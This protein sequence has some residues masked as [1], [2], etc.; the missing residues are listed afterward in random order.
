MHVGLKTA[1]GVRKCG[2]VHQPAP[3][4]NK[5]EQNK[6]HIPFLHAIQLG[7]LG[8]RSQHPHWGGRNMKNS[9]NVHELE[10]VALATWVAIRR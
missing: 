3:L 8:H 5:K 1:V 9:A 7:S 4:E 10:V 2:N 6:Q